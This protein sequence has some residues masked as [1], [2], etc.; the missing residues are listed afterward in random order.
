ML[1]RLALPSR[2]PCDRVVETG[3]RFDLRLSIGF[4]LVRMVFVRQ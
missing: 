2:Q 4:D 3:R 1:D